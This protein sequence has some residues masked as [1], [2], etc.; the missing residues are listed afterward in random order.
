MPTTQI[1]IRL[2]DRLLNRLR[3]L[4]RRRRVQQSTLVREALL[5]LLE[6]STRILAE[7]PYDRIRDLVGSLSG[8]P[9]DLG[10][11][12]REYLRELIGD[13]R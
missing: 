11:R 12:H 1:S 5:A 8:G 2:D 4:A 7:R 13:R 9:R 10:R 3:A 6:P